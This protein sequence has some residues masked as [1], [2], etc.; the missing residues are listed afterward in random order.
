MGKIGEKETFLDKGD[1]IGKKVLTVADSYGGKVATGLAA[2]GAVVA[3]TG[4]GLP[5][6]AGIEVAAGVVGLASK[7]GKYGLMA[8]QA[9][10]DAFSSKKVPSVKKVYRGPQYHNANIV[11]SQS[12]AKR[13]M[14][15]YRKRGM[16]FR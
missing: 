5:L 11:Q 9:F 4:I 7:V 8:G 13:L 15:G 3:A 2:A 14:R 6:A 1:K 12:R 10:N 16:R